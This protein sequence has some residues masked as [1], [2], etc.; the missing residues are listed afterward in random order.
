MPTSGLGNRPRPS[1]VA[2]G[3]GRGGRARP[4]G[5]TLVELLVVVAVVG[6]AAAAVVVS[7]RDPQATQLEREAIR[8]VALLEAARAESRASGVS[9]WWWPGA[10]APVADSEPASRRAGSPGGPTLTGEDRDFRYI[11]LSPGLALPERW[12]EPGV[13]AQVI[14][15]S[16]LVL[17]PEPL[18]GAQRLVL[19]RGEQR[20][21][22]A[23]DGLSP[24]A[25]VDDGA[26]ARP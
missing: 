10:N 5:F 24:F 8:L 15:A 22:L 4:R 9:V 26:Q 20:R 3:H 17:G 2:G 7:V 21:V 14:G 19:R 1:A 12:L 23:T 18:I 13:Q 11:G 16:A 6:I 25:V